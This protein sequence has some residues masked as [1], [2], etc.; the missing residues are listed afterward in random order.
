MDQ[1]GEARFVNGQTF[2]LFRQIWK[3]LAALI[4]RPLRQIFFSAR[5]T[6]ST[7]LYLIIDLPQ[8]EPPPHKLINA[9]ATAADATTRH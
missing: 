7:F 6:F 2:S 5:L 9:A 3:N 4:G 1:F 8:E